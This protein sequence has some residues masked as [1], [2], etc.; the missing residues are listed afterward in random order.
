MY[1]GTKQ[2]YNVGLYELRQALFNQSEFLNYKVL[3]Q[4]MKKNENWTALPRKISNQVWKQVA[5]NWSHWL[6]ALTE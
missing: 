5:G 3:Y 1:V 6:K 4:E 2:L